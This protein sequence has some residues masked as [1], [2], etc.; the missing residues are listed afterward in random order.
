MAERG[1]GLEMSENV[2]EGKVSER[3]KNQIQLQ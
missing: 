2:R 1:C 3:I